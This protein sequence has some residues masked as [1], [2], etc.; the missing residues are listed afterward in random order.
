MNIGTKTNLG[1]VVN[2]DRTHETGRLDKLYTVAKGETYHAALDAA[3]R[4]ECRTVSEW[5]VWEVES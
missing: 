5:Y 2:I 1:Y 4:G 3:G